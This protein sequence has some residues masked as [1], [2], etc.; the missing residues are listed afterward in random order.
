MYVNPILSYF[1]FILSHFLFIYLFILI[2]KIM[3]KNEWN[4]KKINWNL[5]QNNIT[6]KFED[7]IK[8]WIILINQIKSLIE[9]LISLGT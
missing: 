1:I 9:E 7:L 5:G 2:K 6:W 4:G 8:L 3:M